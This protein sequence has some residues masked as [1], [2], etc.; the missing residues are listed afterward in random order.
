M[1]FF[2]LHPPRDGIY[3]CFTHSE[4]RCVFSVEVWMSIV[5]W[6]SV[7]WRPS[8]VWNRNGKVTR[9]VE[10]GSR[11]V[12]GWKPNVERI[13]F[14]ALVL[15]SKNSRGFCFLMFQKEWRNEA[16]RLGTCGF[17]MMFSLE[18][19][20]GVVSKVVIQQNLWVCWPYLEMYHSN[21][22]WSPRGPPPLFRIRPI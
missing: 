14:I 16:A 21:H 2:G 10:I 8:H 19:L 5:P 18:S 15:V 7:A 9:R 11:Q 13:D 6:T 1:V 17:S 12:G 3:L 22:L 20:F 4:K